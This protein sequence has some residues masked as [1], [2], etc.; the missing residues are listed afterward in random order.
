MRAF[1]KATLVWAILAAIG[2]V[3]VVGLGL[4][5]VSARQGHLPGVSW[6]LHTA[7]KNAVWLRAPSEE[8]VPDLTPPSLV[9]LGQ[10]HYENACAFCHAMPGQSRAETALSMLPAPPH[11]TEAVADW[12]PRHMFWIVKNGV[13]MSGMPAWPSQRRDDDVWAVVA[14]LTAVKRGERHGEAQTELPAGGDLAG[15]TGSL[16]LAPAAAVYRDQCLSCHGRD[17]FAG[18]NVFIP[19]LDTLPAAYVAASLQAYRSGARQSG[20]MQQAA[21]Q[22]SDPQIAALAAYIANQ[23]RD[24]LA[25]HE[26]G[27]LDPELVSRGDVLAHGGDEKANIPS[28]VSCHGPASSPRSDHFPP[29]AGQSEVFLRDQLM[30]WKSGR[31][32]GTDRA[33]MMHEAIPDLTKADMLAL[34]QYYAS[35]PPSR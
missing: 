4:Y 23:S 29:L 32:G 13:K 25:E 22:L 28:C 11:I 27:N 14:F 5:N 15:E 6:V 7:Y 21:S 1:L 10:G 2:A 17:G 33:L 9:D 31:R 8:E 3:L 20:I 12:E 34:A 26:V 30:L 16:P 19:R 35:L 18:G 24:R